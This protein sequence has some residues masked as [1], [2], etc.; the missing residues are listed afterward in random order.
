MNFINRLKKTPIDGASARLDIQLNKLSKE[1][2]IRVPCNDPN[3]LSNIN[4]PNDLM[5]N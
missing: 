5:Q 1:E 3:I 2:L 4:T